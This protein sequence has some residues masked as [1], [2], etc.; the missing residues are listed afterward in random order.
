MTHL[1]KLGTKEGKMGGDKQWGEAGLMLTT[2]AF[3]PRHNVY[4]SA[5]IHIW[6]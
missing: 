5:D 6:T 3:Q 2:I 1:N 4:I